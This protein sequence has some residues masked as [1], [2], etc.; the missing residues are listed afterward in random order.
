MTCLN[1]FFNVPKIFTL[2]KSIFVRENRRRYRVP[3]VCRWY[4]LSD[5]VTRFC[6]GGEKLADII[7]GF[8]GGG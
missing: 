2:F 8:C 7:K 6:G 1:L 3:L 5:I 4:R